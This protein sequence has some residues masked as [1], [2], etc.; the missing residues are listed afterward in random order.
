MSATHNKCTIGLIGFGEVGT[1]FSRGFLAAGGYDIAVYDILMDDPDA[2]AAMLEKARSVGVR[3]CASPAEA[4]KNANIIISSV[5][6]SSAVTVAEQ[7]GGYMK[8]GQLFLD[9]NSVSPATKQHDCELVERS[10]ADYVE[11]A[12]MAPVAPYGL[13]VPIVLGG[14]RRAA[15]KELLDPAGMRLELGEDEIG[16]ASALKM[17]RS[18]MV[19]GLEALAVECFTVARLY[20]IEE[21]I[22]ASLSE[23]YKGMNWEQFAGYKIGRVIE[24]GRRRAAEMREAAETVAETGLEPLMSRAIAERIDWAADMVAADPEMKKI[25]DEEWRSMIDRLAKG[26][27]LRRL[28]EG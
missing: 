18:V 7:A 14:K 24:H 23:S 26:A 2:K 3:P 1:T 6:A 16:R 22:L 17:C 5:T 19:K 12:V 11:A 9:I 20:G 25:P 27:N 4:A 10:G 13:K 8:P 21:K 15:V 28:N